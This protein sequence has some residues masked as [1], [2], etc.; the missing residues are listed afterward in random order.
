MRRVC[1][2]L[3]VEETRALRILPT[4]PVLNGHMKYVRIS[5]EWNFMTTKKQL[6]YLFSWAWIKFKVL[7]SAS[8]ASIYIVAILFNYFHASLFGNQTI[9]NITV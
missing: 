4:G 5:I 6:V 7:K 8:I 2:I 9:N 3:T 1:V